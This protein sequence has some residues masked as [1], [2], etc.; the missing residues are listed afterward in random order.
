[1]DGTGGLSGYLE[2]LATCSKMH[3]MTRL[4]IS[5]VQI[6][7]I[8]CITIPRTTSDKEGT[9]GQTSNS[10]MVPRIVKESYLKMCL[11]MWNDADG[12]I[13]LFERIALCSKVLPM[14]R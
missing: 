12:L 9:K 14:T 13:G 8:N 7:D 10:H 1:M 6:A 4:H 11:G 5:P 2:R 3:P